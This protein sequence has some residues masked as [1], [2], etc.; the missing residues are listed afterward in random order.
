M[1][2]SVDGT[3]EIRRLA[4]E[5]IRL[6]GEIDRSEH[7]SAL[8][9][10]E[11][12]CLVRR[13]ADFNAPSWSCDGTGEHSVGALIEHWR[14][15]VVGGAELLGAFDQDEF[16]GLVI[17]DGSFEPG[18]AWLAFLHVS[19]PHRRRGVASVL[20]LA[21]ERIAADAGAKSMYVSATPS[22][23]AVGFYM[24]RGCRLANPPRP[25]LLAEEPE[26]IHFVCSID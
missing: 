3:I 16:L 11:G 20:W 21:A 10:V 6:I 17:V 19:R 8:H 25:D 13:P 24:S 15:V 4:S 23:S 26:D 22:D 2:D 12:G 1:I 9:T 7:V 14:P 5:E 18:M